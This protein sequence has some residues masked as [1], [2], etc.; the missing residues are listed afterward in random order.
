MPT[1]SFGYETHLEFEREAAGPFDKWIYHF[2][3]DGVAAGWFGLIEKQLSSGYTKIEYQVK[4]AIDEPLAFM[5]S[6]GS[7]EQ[8]EELE[9]LFAL[10][11]DKKTEEAEIV[12]TLFAVWNDFLLNEVSPTDEQIIQEVRENWHPAKAKFSSVQL[13]QW[14]GWLRDNKIIP[15]GKGTE[16]VYQKSLIH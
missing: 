11:A 1:T 4:S 13:M 7:T 2:E 9:R 16:T 3:R 10:F 12:A 6:V 5:N 14:L 8:R 15:T